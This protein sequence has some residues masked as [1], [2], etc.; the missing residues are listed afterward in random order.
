[1]AKK[2]TESEK[3]LNILSK[4]KLKQYGINKFKKYMISDD[5]PSWKR[6]KK[7]TEV[8]GFYVVVY[9]KWRSRIICRTFYISQR[10]YNNKKITKLFEVKRQ[11]A[12]CDKQLTRRLYSSMGGGIKCWTYDF[13][14]YYD[15]QNKDDDEWQIHNIKSFDV[16]YYKSVY[17]GYGCIEN[18]YYFVDTSSD[19]LKAMLRNSIYRYSGFEYSDF[20]SRELF[21]YLAIYEKHPQ[22][23]MISKLGLSYLLED[24]LRVFRWSKKGLDILEIEKR[25][26]EKLKGLRIS[27]KVFKKYKALI[28]KFNINDITEFNHLLKLIEISKIKYANINISQYSFD[29]FKDQKASMYI[30][31]D[32]Y[33]FCERLGLP[34]NH[35]NKYPDN[36]DVA[37]DRLLMQIETKENVERDLKIR[38]LVNSELFKYRYADENF[39]IT[40]ANSTA[41]LINESKG[42]DHCVRTYDERY[43][44]GDTFIFLVRKREDVNTP[45]YTLELSNKKEIKQLKGRK[46]CKATNEVNNFVK[47]WANENKLELSIWRDEDE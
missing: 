1:M 3:L 9:E 13:S 5:D 16:S 11:L 46:N 45:F 12:G 18:G 26:I 4:L 47:K 36:I 7:D 14:Y 43:A 30:I 33:S 35:E 24:D 22:I 15:Y 40:P 8:Y 10:W 25:D 29:Y 34:M 2:L 37:H 20:N 39:V 31:K 41:D 6:P 21:K 19:D 42:L 38:E 32:Y 27:L 28:Y 17:A 44:N 23:E